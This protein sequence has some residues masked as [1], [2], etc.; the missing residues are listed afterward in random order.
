MC[1]LSMKSV[2]STDEVAHFAD[3]IAHEL[4]SQLDRQHIVSL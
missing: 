4:S 2:H 3:D 1:D